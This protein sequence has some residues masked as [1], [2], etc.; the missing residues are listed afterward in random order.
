MYSFNVWSGDVAMNG[1]GKNYVKWV[2]NLRIGHSQLHGHRDLIIGLFVFKIPS[3]NNLVSTV[4]R[5]QSEWPGLNFCWR[6]EILWFWR[7]FRLAVGPTTTTTTTMQQRPSWEAESSSAVQEILW[8][9]QKPK[10]HYHIHKCPSPVLKSSLCLLI[11][12]L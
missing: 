4:T 9:L 6:Q 2:L 8:I 1:E 12:L 5:L 11:P 10:V 3:W 7:T